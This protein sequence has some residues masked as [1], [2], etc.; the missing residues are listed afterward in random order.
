MARQQGLTDLSGLHRP[1]SKLGAFVGEHINKRLPDPM[2][3]PD[4][5]RFIKTNSTRY[6]IASQW[7]AH[8]CR[9]KPL[10]T[11]FVPTPG[12]HSN[13]CR[14]LPPLTTQPTDHFKLASIASETRDHCAVYLR[15]IIYS[16]CP[17]SFITYSLYKL[18]L[19]VKYW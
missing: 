3:K 12:N 5:H 17:S 14:G 8:C 2:C 1:C 13:P 15:Y 11:I 18:L 9:I 7:T 19:L 4:L 10:L 16:M 6:N